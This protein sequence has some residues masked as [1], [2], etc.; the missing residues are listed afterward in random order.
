MLR[1]LHR[2]ARGHIHVAGQNIS[3]P[4]TISAWKL[5]F[6]QKH[7]PVAKLPKIPLWRCGGVCTP[8]GRKVK[9]ISMPYAHASQNACVVKVLHTG[10]RAVHFENHLECVVCSKLWQCVYTTMRHS[11]CTCYG[12]RSII[13][14]SRWIFWHNTVLWSWSFF[15]GIDQVLTTF[16]FDHQQTRIALLQLK[17]TSKQ[18]IS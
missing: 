9:T 8:K 6:D 1:E 7:A 13:L 16:R 10:T 11:E 18:W 4:L 17:I 15:F 2:K 3:Y 5:H 12:A 14:R